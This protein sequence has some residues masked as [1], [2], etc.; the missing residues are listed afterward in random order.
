MIELSR[1]TLLAALDHAL[2]CLDGVED[3]VSPERSAEYH[4]LLHDVL[5]ARV[6][7]SLAKHDE[8]LSP[9][10]RAQRR[11]NLRVLAMRVGAERILMRAELEDLAPLEAPTG[12]N[13]GG[14]P[15]CG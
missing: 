1:E 13:D 15:P 12:D 4:G 9:E 11:V 7:A 6:L 5:A 8:G 14:E 10:E 2:A 3:G